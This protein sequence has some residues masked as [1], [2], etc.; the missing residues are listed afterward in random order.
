M[1]LILKYWKVGVI[2]FALVALLIGYRWQINN[3]Y[4]RG[5]TDANASCLAQAKKDVAEARDAVEKYKAEAENDKIKAREQRERDT[6]AQIEW[7]EKEAKRNERNVDQI[8]KH[9]EEAL[10]SSPACAAWAEQVVPCP[11]E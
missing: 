9:F 11:V 1:L 4:D 10:K 2:A 5:K 3:A 7:Q 8:R 6:Q